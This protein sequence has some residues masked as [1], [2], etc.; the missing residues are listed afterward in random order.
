MASI[1]PNLPPTGGGAPALG[2]VVSGAAP[3]LAGT[4]GATLPTDN[5]SGLSSVGPCLQSNSQ[6]GGVWQH[7]LGTKGGDSGGAGSG[8]LVSNLNTSELAKTFGSSSNDVQS[9]ASTQQSLT[10]GTAQNM[11]KSG[12]L[13]AIEPVLNERPDLQVGQLTS[14]NGTQLSAV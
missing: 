6:L 10:V 4:P 7:S 3:A 13:Q 5:T 8:A 1:V 9:L 2:P 11:A 12:T 14:N